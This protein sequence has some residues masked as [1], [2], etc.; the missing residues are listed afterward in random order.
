[1]TFFNPLLQESVKPKKLLDL[2]AQE[3]LI[4]AEITR[5]KKDEPIRFFKPHPKQDALI[6]SKATIRLA[7][8][9]NRS[10]KTEVGMCE[11]YANALGCRPWLS[12]DDPDYYTKFKH[13][14]KIRVY[15]EDFGNHLK[16][17]ICPKMR[18]WISKKDLAAPA[19][20]NQQ[21]VDVFWQIRSIYG[22]V[23]TIELMSYEQGSEKMEGW[24]G[25]FIW[26][27]EPPS[28]DIF[29]AA[30]RGLTDHDGLAVFTM[31]PLKEPWIFDD[32]WTRQ[33]DSYEEDSL[34]GLREDMDKE[35]EKLL[36]DISIYGVTM[37]MYDNIGFGLTEKS[38]KQFE[39][40]LD[41]NEKAA[42][43]HGRFTH[44]QG[45]VYNSF[46]RNVHVL[47]NDVIDEILPDCTVYEAIDPHPRKP[48]AVLFVAVAPDDTVYVYDELWY[49]GLVKNCAEAI[50]I[51]REDRH[52][53]YTLIDPIACTPDPVSGT[54]MMDDFK[55][56]GVPTLKGSKDR[57]R[58][59]DLL[60][61]KLRIING[62]PGIFIAKR[63]TRTIYEFF[64]YVWDDFSG[65]AADKNDVK[66]TPRK[67]NDDMLEC[68][69]RILIS[70]ARFRERRAPTRK[71]FQGLNH[72]K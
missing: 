66:G 52:P 24:D 49:K 19:K 31:T 45:L 17:V 22:G 53:V 38:V 18:K 57:A 43:I 69:H 42:R 25:H 8:G 46:D 13:P 28:R 23:S 56:H 68:L 33:T 14:I 11:M 71:K 26:F 51:K 55:N 54:T 67:K 47:P 5:R 72:S 50:K 58:G 27:D 29:I 21:G 16:N 40:L 39:A 32:L 37:D 2:E 70:G 15:G 48:H 30:F 1:M 36:A 63:C 3:Q 12:E 34:T 41:E 64:H 61:G 65:K 10:G 62:R 44:L 35:V 4:L 7:L 6:R 60:N 9:G 59:I 20:K